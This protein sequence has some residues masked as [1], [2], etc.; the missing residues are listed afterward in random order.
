MLFRDAYNELVVVR[1]YRTADA[2]MAV[3]D[4]KQDL[5]MADKQL[6]GTEWDHPSARQRS[7]GHA[8]DYRLV[9]VRGG[10][11][12]GYADLLL[13]EERDE[14]KMVGPVYYYLSGEAIAPPTSAVWV[15]RFLIAIGQRLFGVVTFRGR[16]YSEMLREAIRQVGKESG[17]TSMRAV[18]PG[19]FLAGLRRVEPPGQRG[20]Y[21]FDITMRSPIQ[22]VSQPTP[23][24]AEDFAYLTEHAGRLVAASFLEKI[25]RRPFHPVRRQA[26][27]SHREFVSAGSF[28]SFRYLRRDDKHPWL[29]DLKPMEDY[30]GRQLALAPRTGGWHPYEVLW[31]VWEQLYF[32]TAMGLDLETFLELVRG[33]NP[34]A[35]QPIEESI[36]A[37][38]AAPWDARGGPG[39]QSLPVVR[40]AFLATLPPRIQEQIVRAMAVDEAV[41]RRLTRLAFTERY[42]LSPHEE[43]TLA[44]LLYT[45]PPASRAPP[46]DPQTPDAPSS[47][48]P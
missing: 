48:R 38:R 9:V 12:V 41:E 40:D 37:L 21:L 35:A 6:R 42:D 10:H 20:W 43:Q 45:E 26:G 14:R 8:P 1:Q 28:R 29:D 24:S 19:A 32:Q 5:T 44:E 7:I 47:A 13:S 30:Y 25:V 18:V 39:T 22:R 11:T 15:K 31:A 27:V 2:E 4:V 23:T 33:W 16:G 3:P 46:V 17:A 34:N 36:A